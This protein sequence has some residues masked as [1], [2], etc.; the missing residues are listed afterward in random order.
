MPA[1]IAALFSAPVTNEEVITQQDAPDQTLDC[2]FQ[3]AAYD[4]ASDEKPEDPS[5]P[6]QGHADIAP[7]SGSRRRIKTEPPADDDDDP[8]LLNALSRLDPPSDSSSD[9]EDD[10]DIALS[11]SRRRVKAEP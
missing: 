1:W 8:E 10:H 6:T 3:Q 11:D 5:A 7:L 9:S 4:G 2:K